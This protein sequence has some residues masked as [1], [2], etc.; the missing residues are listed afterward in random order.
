LE[1]SRKFPP[2]FLA[3]KFSGKITV[4]FRKNSAGIFPNIVF[5]KKTSKKNLTILTT[6]VNS[7]TY[8]FHLEPIWKSFRLMCMISTWMS[9]L[10]Y[11]N[12]Y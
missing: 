3:E 10:C 1:N 5:E 4:N 7:Q 9:W 11:W 6:T 2:D 12:N 8:G